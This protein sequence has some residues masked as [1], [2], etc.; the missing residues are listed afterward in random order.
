LIK[1]I[2]VIL[3]SFSQFT[4]S[5]LY[6]FGRNKVQ[7]NKFEW[8][9]LKTEHFDIYYYGENKEIAEI[10]GNYAEEIFSELKIKLNYIVTRRVPLIFYNTHLQFQETNTIP[11]FIPEGVGGFFEFVK[12]RVV[13][14]ATGSLTDFKHVI[15]HEIVHVFMSGKVYNVLH[16]HRK[17]TDYSPP[18]W[19]TEGLAEFLSTKPDAQAEMVMRDAIISGYFYN[20]ENIYQ[21]YGTFLM[22]K[23][24]QNFLEFITEKY[25]EEIVPLLLD[26]IWMFSKFNDDIEYTIG[27]PIEEIDS[28]WEFYL[29]RKYYPLMKNNSPIENAARQITDFGYNFSPVFYN[30]KGKKY[31]YF[32][33][34]RD[35]YSSLYRLELNK[36]NNFKK[37]EEPELV[38]RGEKTEE[39]ESFHLFQSSIDVSQNGIIA[40][41]TKSGETDVIHFFSAKENK[42]EKDFQRENLITI[43]SPKFSDDGNKITFQAVDQK[44]F[45][46]IYLFDIPSDS[47]TRL[48][49]DYYDDQNPSF[50]IND[51]QIIFSSDRTAGEFEKKYNLFSYDLSSHQIKYVTYLDADCFSSRLS[52]KKDLLL[53]TSDYDGVRNIYK[54]NVVAGTFGNKV[55]KVTHFIT[56]AFDPDFADDSTIAFSGF[57][58]FLFNL[59]ETNIKSKNDSLPEKVITMNIDSAFGAWSPKKYIAS[60]ENEKLKYRRQY[61][62]DYAAGQVST[63]YDP[64]YGTRGGAVFVLSDLFGDDNY[65][66]YIYNTAEV[67]SDILKSFNISIEKFDLSKRSNYG[68]GVFNFSGRRYDITQSDNY[69]YERSFGGF[70]LLDFPLSKFQ[71]IESS[72]TVANSDKEDLNGLNER[73]ALLIGNSISYVVDNSLWGPTGPLDGIRARLLLGYTGDVKYSNVNYFSVIADYRQYFRLG[74]STALALRAAL[75]YN[76]GK[77]ARRYFM[78]GSWDLRGWPEF[79]IRGQKMWISS[80]EFRFPLID[81]LRVKFPFFGLSFFGLRGAAYFDAGSAWDTDYISTLGSLG[82][83]IRFNLFGVIVLRY[84][85]GK[86]I[87]NNFNQFQPGLFYQFFF[88]WDF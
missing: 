63:A 7:Y 54:I 60:S 18:L 79:S 65:F 39:L 32:V 43:S 36:E 33:A 77:E 49:N 16:E 73:K 26:N 71:R 11:G 62:L 61:T 2:F 8:K 55:K 74:F 42:I 66:F 14:P 58:N 80:V 70:F 3:F 45:S 87:E 86:K 31:L 69:F 22:Y 59:Y 38:L 78:G 15:R 19:F 76:Q 41:V 40:F 72:V 5:Q 50:G 25:G 51:N 68:F 83:G 48:T 35:G 46:D 24:G 75:F 85:I 28:E 37:R 64:I 21:I 10:G 52:P 56:G 84:D 1:Y 27:K 47:L 9:I 67:Q 4:F 6:F 23:E 30:L 82:T 34:N 53:F 88:G 17:P 12:G 29:K 57:E 20:L 81:E 13:I 44:G